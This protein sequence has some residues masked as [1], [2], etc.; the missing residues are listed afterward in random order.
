MNSAYPGDPLPAP[1]RWR[2]GRPLT[3]LQSDV[4][5]QTATPLP[6]SGRVPNYAPTSADRARQSVGMPSLAVTHPLT[7]S[8]ET[9][10]RA[11]SPSIAGGS[12]VLLSHAGAPRRLCDA[13]VR[14]N[15]HRSGCCAVCAQAGSG[16]A[17]DESRW[18]GRE[19]NGVRLR[20]TL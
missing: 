14:T 7:Q 10:G 3:A 17:R 8:R 5:P 12:A 15:W 18:G 20:L 13:V 1:F 11:A 2:W 9:G 6:P 19:K 4:S 16:C